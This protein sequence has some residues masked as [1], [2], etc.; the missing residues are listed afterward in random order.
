MQLEN[1][2][3]LRPVKYLFLS[4]IFLKIIQILRVDNNN[5]VPAGIRKEI[6]SYF[7]RIQIREF[8]RCTVLHIIAVF[9]I[10]GIYRDKIAH[11][12]RYPGISDLFFLQT[13]QHLLLAHLAVNVVDTYDNMLIITIHS[14]KLHIHVGWYPFNHQTVCKIERSLLIKSLNYIFPGKGLQHRLPVRFIYHLLY[15]PAAF[16]E[17]IIATAFQCKSSSASVCRIFHEL[18][19]IH[20]NMIQINVV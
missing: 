19:C 2:S 10:H 15:I 14:C 9:G 8:L 4:K 12:C 18:F 7:G 20:I 1:F 3:I 16:R 6:H 13:F 5:N 17:E 11:Q